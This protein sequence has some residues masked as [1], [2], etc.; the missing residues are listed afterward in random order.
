M[1]AYNVTA[2]PAM[3]DYLSL[4]PDSP[5]KQ[6]ID[7]LADKIYAEMTPAQVYKRGSSRSGPDTT[8]GRGDTS[9]AVA[10]KQAIAI[11]A[12][13]QN[14]P[15][16]IL[17]ANP[18]PEVTT[19]GN[20]PAPGLTSSAGIAGRDVRPEEHHT[21]P[22]SVAAYKHKPTS[23]PTSSPAGTLPE[24]TKKAVA[25][26]FKQYPEYRREL[27]S[28]L[29]ASGQGF[30][31]D[32][33]LPID[34]SVELRE[35]GRG[36][37]ETLSLGI[38]DTG[39]R[40]PRAGDIDVFGMN[41]SPSG[42]VGNVAGALPMAIGGGIAGAGLAARAGLG[43]AGQTVGRIVGGEAVP[44]F[45]EG[46][47]KSD[48]DID[49]ALKMA[50]VWTATGLMLE[51]TGRLAIKGIR[52]MKENKRLTSEQKLAIEEYDRVA[53]GQGVP[54]LGAAPDPAGM[55]RWN[56]ES[57]AMGVS[58]HVTDND[59]AF[60]EAFDQLSAG[61]EK[62][63]NL[64]MNR[65]L[66]VSLRK[67]SLWDAAAGLSDEVD[68]VFTGLTKLT[69]ERQVRLK[70]DMSSVWRALL[71]AVDEGKVDHNTAE[72]L[73]RQVGLGKVDADEVINS[74]RSAPNL[75]R[76]A[77]KR[78][79]ELETSQWKGMQEGLS[80]EAEESWTEFEAKLSRKQKRKAGQRRGR[81][82]GPYIRRKRRGGRGGGVDP[83]ESAATG[84]D[85]RPATQD[86][87]S[88]IHEI[89][90]KLRQE[91]DNF[92]LPGPDELR[93]Y[94]MREARKVEVQAKSRLSWTRARNRTSAINNLQQEAADPSG[95]K[96][97]WVDNPPKDMTPG[98]QS[99]H[100]ELARKQKLGRVIYDEAEL[101]REPGLLYHL[102]VVPNISR[103][104]LG[105]NPV[106]KAVLEKSMHMLED[107]GRQKAALWKRYT[108]AIQPLEASRM[109]KIGASVG[110]QGAREA[111][112]TEARLK[113]QLVQALDGRGTNEIL[114]ANAE[115]VPIYNE[116]RTIFDELAD[117]LDLPQSE[118]ISDYF[119]HLFGDDTALWRAMRM[120]ND[121]GEQSRFVTKY[122]PDEIANEIPQGRFFG[123]LIERRG[124]DAAF[125]EDLDAVMYAYMHGA[126]ETPRYS[127]FLRDAN[128]ALEM[129]PADNVS[130]RKAFA[131]WTNYVVGRPTN[132]KTAQ[133]QWWQENATFN[134]WVDN[135]VEWLGDAETK[136]LLARSRKGQLSKEEEKL[137][138]DFFDKLLVDANKFTAEGQLKGRRDMKQYRAHLALVVDDMRAALGNAAARPIVMEKLYQLMVINKLGFSVSHMLTNLT[139]SLT[140]TLPKVGLRYMS[141][142]V[143]RYTGDRRNEFSNGR[144]V[145]EVIEESG[146]LADIPEYREFFGQRKTG[147]IAKA[148]D[149]ALQPAKI[150]E[151]F[152]RGVALLGRYEQ[153][154]D[155]GMDHAAALVDARELVR[156]TQFVFNKAA[157]M[158][159]FRNPGARFLLMFQSYTLHQ[160]N[161]SAELLHD[162]IA[163]GE[164]GPLFKHLLAYVTLG[165]G[166]AALSETAPN[167][168]DQT[169]H[170]LIGLV[171]ADNPLD[172]MGGP[173]SDMLM[174]MLQ[175]NV[176]QALSE[177]TT[178]SIERRI[179]RTSESG[180]IMQLLGFKSQ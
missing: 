115:L 124:T 4:P 71:I 176:S 104:G 47:V 174:E 108:A 123:S 2:D 89:R 170:P 165:A 142:G 43:V 51:G 148:S 166:A 8:T 140:N 73:F 42:M 29:K 74:V 114:E 111:L 163:K 90:G 157:T 159:L 134:R 82:R 70:E 119:P 72:I 15:L 44:G 172:A 53:K 158:P 61:V 121:L 45:I 96:R 128:E 118:R 103:W 81:G 143:K 69:P 28:A 101:N 139:Q 63:N 179:E 85:A 75:G 10:L 18:P 65:F 84:V 35:M 156:N 87:V 173:P 55:G 49:E 164:T 150:S 95:M 22:A 88:R 125:S 132:W 171:S 9:R 131:N 162:A 79:G 112:E 86:Q 138:V 147:F 58:P 27:M 169:S 109:Q 154:I 141:K 67:E 36:A 98:E 122:L 130:T 161:F 120:S 178:P 168:Q 83:P 16:E 25:E 34:P 31:V 46:L 5:R 155:E 102:G 64:A 180:E 40:D 11:E 19:Q 50:G 149:V 3:G 1:A 26:V 105:S 160:M 13:E 6:R 23:Q 91:G 100:K 33:Y 127:V 68:E 66:N 153:A 144:N 99:M 152:N 52:R 30:D 77:Q 110:R 59:Q 136:G 17:T 76:R 133:A 94:N 54:L 20:A 137:A 146:V 57:T 97:Y 175:G 167:L 116:L 129:L 177:L 117:G 92:E 37:L 7:R 56:V 14:S 60:R 39:E 135:A 24:E 126:I 113:G 41:L 93:G 12:Q 62:V 32:E 78:Q 151:E 107:I 38:A 106:T 21:V 145:E 48:G 80:D